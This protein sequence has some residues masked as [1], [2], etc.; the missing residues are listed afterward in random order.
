[1]RLWYVLLANCECAEPTTSTGS[2][3][4]GDGCKGDCDAT[5]M[6]GKFSDGG[7]VKCGLDL[8]CSWGGW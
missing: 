3:F 5:A 8:C 2:D 4:C 1:M 6:C 7:N